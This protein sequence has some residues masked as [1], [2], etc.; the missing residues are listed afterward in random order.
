MYPRW[1]GSPVCAPAGLLAGARLRHADVAA[2]AGPMTAPMWIQRGATRVATGSRT[3]PTQAMNV[4]LLLVTTLMG[5]V[6]LIEKC[7]GA[8]GFEAL[9]TERRWVVHISGGS[10]GR[11]DLTPDREAVGHLGPPFGRAEQMPSRPEVCG[12]AAEGGQEPLR[13]PRRFEAFHRP[14]ALPGG[15][16]R[17]LGAVVQ[18]PLLPV[19]SPTT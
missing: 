12:D 5:T 6:T 3:P 9:V 10:V 15:L 13:M 7:S 11:G 1:A 14:F 18:V 8:V 17:V 19:S 4:F 16:M 2:F